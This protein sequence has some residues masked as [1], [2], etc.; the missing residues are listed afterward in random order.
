MPDLR[1]L[2]TD[3]SASPSAALDAWS[4]DDDERTGL[5]FGLSPAPEPASADEDSGGVDPLAMP[6]LY[7]VVTCDGYE[8]S[9][10]WTWAGRRV[11]DDDLGEMMPTAPDTLLPTVPILTHIGLQPVATTP[12]ATNPGT[13]PCPGI[14]VGRI[15]GH[16]IGMGTID[17]L[18]PGCLAIPVD[19]FARWPYKELLHRSEQIA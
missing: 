14:P 3:P 1:R 6:D 4:D 2:R 7:R 11:D 12:L 18:P 16:L 5:P 19:R 13:A 17:G 10:E 8:P 9:S 15:A